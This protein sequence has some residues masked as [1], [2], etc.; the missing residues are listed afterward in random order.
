MLYQLQ[1]LINLSEKVSGYTL[2]HWVETCGRLRSL[3]KRRSAKKTLSPELQQDAPARRLFYC[4]VFSIYLPIWQ[5]SQKAG[6]GYFKKV[7]FRFDLVGFPGQDKQTRRVSIASS[8]KWIRPCHAAALCRKPMFT[9]RYTRYLSSALA[10]EITYIQA[11]VIQINIC[12]CLI[13]PWS[14]VEIG[15]DW[16][17]MDSLSETDRP[18]REFIT[19]AGLSAHVQNPDV[20]WPCQNQSRN[21]QV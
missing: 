18:S 5:T 3:C 20:S 17:T 6:K 9:T 19:W 11:N 12:F 1:R 2:S 7:L 21:V 13:F 8:R 4:T 14:A 16:S 15:G 10:K